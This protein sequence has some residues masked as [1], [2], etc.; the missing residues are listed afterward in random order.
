MPKKKAAKKKPGKTARRAAAKRGLAAKY[1]PLTVSIGRKKVR[2]HL[3][4][5]RKGARHI[6]AYVTQGY[7]SRAAM[8]HARQTDP[9]AAERIRLRGEAIERMRARAAARTKEHGDIFTPNTTVIPYSEWSKSMTP[10][11]RKGAAKK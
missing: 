5:T 10:T 6:P 4:K 3:Y 2:T 9:K 8:E 11:K 1:K 7:P